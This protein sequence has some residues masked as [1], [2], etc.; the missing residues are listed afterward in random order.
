[1]YERMSEV[2]FKYKIV[3]YVDNGSW[4]G[5][6]GVRLQHQEHELPVDQNDKILEE[7]EQSMRSIYYYEQSFFG[8]RNVPEGIFPT[9]NYTGENLPEDY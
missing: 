9:L 2:A 1:M 6:N 4:G 8:N 7:L 3:P 5:S